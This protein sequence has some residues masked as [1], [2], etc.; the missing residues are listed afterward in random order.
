MRLTKQK[1]YK[2]IREAMYENQQGVLG[3]VQ[4]MVD[5]NKWLKG[6]QVN[7][8]DLIPIS[9][10]IILYASEE[11][12]SHIK[13]RHQ[14][15]NAPGSLI[16]PNVNIKELIL[17]IMKTPPNSTGRGMVKWEGIESPGGPIGQMGLA[18]ASPQ[19]VVPLQDYK[20]PG[21]RGEVVKVAPGERKETNEVTL[22]TSNLGSVEDGRVVL[23]L[24]TLYPGGMDVDGVQVPFDRGAFAAAGI[25]FVLPPGSPILKGA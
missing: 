1:L 13:D 19:E 2:L 6:T 22:V 20:M 11:G 4:A 8:G 23:S 16:Y 21:G 9:D 3:Q 25:Y 24:V 15:A 14:D 7:E 5:G 12:M 18:A 17:A 10:K